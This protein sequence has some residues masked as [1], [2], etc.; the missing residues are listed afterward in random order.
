M[1]C[2]CGTSRD[3]GAP[4][5]IG[6]SSPHRHSIHTGRAKVLYVRCVTSPSDGW[7]F[8]ER[9]IGTVAKLTAHVRGSDYDHKYSRNPGNYPAVEP[10]LCVTE[11][12]SN[13]LDPEGILSLSV[14]GVTSNPFSVKPVLHQFN[15]NTGRTR[16]CCWTTETKVLLL[17]NRKEA[18]VIGQQE[19]RFGH[20]T[21]SLCGCSPRRG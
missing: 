2:Q 10:S 15:D 7:A 16:C 6:C 3:G 9:N 1:A 19:P 17:D 11:I 14:T 5:C 8:V 12:T 20:W 13:S 18:D 21:T 4:L